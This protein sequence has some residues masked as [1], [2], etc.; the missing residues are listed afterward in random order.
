MTTRQI[1]IAAKG[2]INSANNPAGGPDTADMTALYTVI[3]HPAPV[4]PPRPQITLTR[5]GS[6]TVLS[7]SGDAGLFT[8]QSTPTLSPAAWANVSPNRRL[9]RRLATR[10]SI[11]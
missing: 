6:N 1:C 7:W 9:C 5:L 11:L 3:G 10:T 8:L 4:P 2:M